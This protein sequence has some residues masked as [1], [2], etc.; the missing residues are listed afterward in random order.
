MK[1][2]VIGLGTFGSSIAEKLAGMGN[3]V[4]GVDISMSKVEAIKEKITHAIS[5]DAT[6]MEAVKNLPI[7]MVK[8]STILE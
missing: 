1:Y 5:L 3:E 2:I 6:D 4:I 8:M 7:N